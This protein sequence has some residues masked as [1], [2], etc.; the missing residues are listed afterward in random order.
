VLLQKESPV[1][2]AKTL[3][4]GFRFPFIPTKQYGTF[5][6]IY[7]LQHCPM[8][9]HPKPLG[10]AFLKSIPYLREACIAHSV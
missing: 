2:V 9:I 6:I 10:T 8:R 1:D 3:A 7:N 5:K 4:R